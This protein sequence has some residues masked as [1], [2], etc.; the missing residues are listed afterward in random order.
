LET[1][2]NENSAI[3]KEPNFLKYLL[4]TNEENGKLWEIHLNYVSELPLTQSN[5]PHQ[6]IVF[7][8]DSVLALLTYL[9][10]RWKTISLHT[11]QFRT[12]NSVMPLDRSTS[13]STNAP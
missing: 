1:D 11:E 13:T 6:H 4:F 5:D 2:S 12:I 7:K 9:Q 3:T 10:E 8:A